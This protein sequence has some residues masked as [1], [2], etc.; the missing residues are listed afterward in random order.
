MPKEDN[1][2]DTL[3]QPLVPGKA[4]SLASDIKTLHLKCLHLFKA[5]RPSQ[6][7]VPSK[8]VILIFVWSLVVG[9]MYATAVNA[10]VTISFELEDIFDN[11]FAVVLVSYSFL[12]LSLLFYPFAGFLADVYCGRYRTVVAGMAIMCVSCLIVSIGSFLLFKYYFSNDP[13]SS[14]LLI[15]FSVIALVW[16]IFFAIGLAGYRANVIQLGLDQLITFPSKYLGLFVHWV[17]WS[18]YVGMLS[19][20]VLFA[21]LT[22]ASYSDLV[23]GIALSLPFFFTTILLALLL[24]SVYSRRWFRTEKRQQNSY[25]MVI[26]VLN[27]ARK[28]KKPI[29]RTAETYCDRIRPSRLDYTKERYG[30]PFTSE[31]AEDVKTFL[32]IFGVLVCLCFVFILEVPTSYFMFPLFA[33]HAGTGEDLAHINCTGR[34]IVLETG[35]LEYMTV[36]LFIPLYVCLIYSGVI[37]RIPKIL[38][39]L[40]LSYFLYVVGALSMMV[41]DIVGHIVRRHDHSHHSEECMLSG[42]FNL[43]FDFSQHALALHWSVL[44][45]PCVL[46]GVAQ[47]LVT[48]TA[49]E[50]ISAQSPHSMKGLLVGIFFAFKGLFQLLSSILLVP[51]SVKEVWNSRGHNTV[52]SCEFGYYLLTILI[53]VCGL[54]LFSVVARRY[55]YR[56]RGELPYDQSDIED[57]YIRMINAGAEVSLRERSSVSDM[58]SILWSNSLQF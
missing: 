36:V 38:V 20:S 39:R 27:F 10:C 41:I 3:T 7:C 34:W 55:K 19:M 52:A 43:N 44:A 57:V 32:R 25:K 50:F 2:Q 46:L 15:G 18:F 5:L 26:Q 56:Q 4:S 6:T 14:R 42:T 23:R 17:G 11:L 35:N 48:F 40:W 33:L 9:A 45:L 22:C 54:V 24:F 28:H 12:A 53:A 49:F 29:K 21:S 30:G 47:M 37:I 8:A 16:F 58:N 13:L 1:E 51:F 31:Q